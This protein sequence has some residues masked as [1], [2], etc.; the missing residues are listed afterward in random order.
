M[1]KKGWDDGYCGDENNV[2]YGPAAMAK[3][4]QNSTRHQIAQNSATGIE[5][6]RHAKLALVGAA[7]RLLQLKSV[8]SPEEDRIL[9]QILVV[10]DCGDKDIMVTVPDIKFNVLRISSG[11]TTINGISVDVPIS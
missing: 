10:F 2:V 8:F 5:A 4:A 9:R 3:E 11:L 1:S 7:Q 6:H